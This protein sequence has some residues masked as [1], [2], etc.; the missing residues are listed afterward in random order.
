MRAARLL[1][2]LG[3]AALAASGCAPL[4]RPLY[5]IDAPPAPP[6]YARPPRPNAAA[7]WIPGRWRWTGTAYAWKRGHWEHRPAGEVW[8]AGYWKSTHRGWTWVP[9]HWKR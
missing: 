5:V 4:R 7:V 6:H 2:L 8:I 1:L 9:G 3:A